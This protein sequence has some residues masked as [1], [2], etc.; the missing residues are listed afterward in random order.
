[1]SLDAGRHQCNTSP[2]RP[3]TLAVFFSD[4][5]TLNLLLVPI[6][7]PV[8]DP[9]LLLTH[10]GLDGLRNGSTDRA[11]AHDCQLFWHLA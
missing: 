5:T 4:V 1:M 2:S 7:S 6:S 10:G 8:R 11:S 9:A 3:K